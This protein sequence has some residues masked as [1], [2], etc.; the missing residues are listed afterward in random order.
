[1][2]DQEES[3]IQTC[4]HCYRKAKVY[5]RTFKCAEYTNTALSGLTEMQMY[6]QDDE[7]VYAEETYIGDRFI[8]ASAQEGLS[9]GNTSQ[10]FYGTVNGVCHRVHLL[11]LTTDTGD[12]T[13][14]EYTDGVLTQRDQLESEA[15]FV[16]PTKGAG[17]GFDIENYGD[18]PSDEWYA[19]NAIVGCKCGIYGLCQD[20]RDDTLGR[21]NDAPFHGL[22]SPET[23]TC[24]RYWCEKGDEDDS[25]ECLNRT[26]EH[27]DHKC[28]HTYDCDPF[29]MGCLR[30]QID[31]QDAPGT[32]Y[33]DCN[34]SG[35]CYPEGDF[36]LVWEKHPVHSCTPEGT[37][38]TFGDQ[39][40][41]TI[42]DNAAVL[43]TQGTMK[44]IEVGPI[45][46]GAGLEVPPYEKPA[47]AAADYDKHEYWDTND[48]YEIP[49]VYY[50]CN[51]YVFTVVKEQTY[52]NF[53]E[54]GVWND[55]VIEEIDLPTDTLFT[56]STTRLTAEDSQLCCPVNK[57]CQAETQPFTF[58]ETGNHICVNHYGTWD[59]ENE[60]DGTG[61]P[62]DQENISCEPGTSLPEDCRQILMCIPERIQ[63]EE[64]QKDIDWNKMIEEGGWSGLDSSAYDDVDQEDPSS[65]P[66]YTWTDRD[67][68]GQPLV[69]YALTGS[70][71]CECPVTSSDWPEFIDALCPESGSETAELDDMSDIQ[72]RKWCMDYWRSQEVGILDDMSD[73]QPRK[74][75]MDYWRSQEVGIQSS[76]QDGTSLTADAALDA[77]LKKRGWD[78]A[79]CPARAPDQTV[80][81]CADQG[82]VCGDPHVTT[83]FGQKYD[84]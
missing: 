68:Q 4:S 61:D 42:D 80:Q 70:Q 41:H 24:K 15:A 45:G 38:W 65:W 34:E 2:A 40:D 37:P 57:H 71:G 6:S 75:C 46:Q 66:G 17:D 58:V 28:Y 23:S 8:D 32:T 67:Y 13:G 56:S 22:D 77:W 36:F 29:D 16:T 5:T 52:N 12:N 39:P 27:E 20:G 69:T 62:T 81:T 84:M 30:S 7:S 82:T 78:I 25:D 51:K 19:E 14:W 48:T 26:N 54:A 49:A 50:G 59:F 53:A 74:W 83:F 10:D 73:I 55:K 35:G 76:A 43:I 18:T 64:D 33:G 63:I 9:S 79:R 21:V 3:E 31:E 60:C 1:M 44:D 11:G 47:D 72:P